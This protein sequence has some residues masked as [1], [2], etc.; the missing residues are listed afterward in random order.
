ML[1]PATVALLLAVSI[2]SRMD[3]CASLAKKIGSAYI[4][5]VATQYLPQGSVIDHRS[6]GLDVTYQMT[7]APPMPVGL[8]RAI[9]NV[10]T[11]LSS[12]IMVEAWLPDESKGRLLSVGNRKFDGC[13]EYPQMAHGMYLGFATVSSNGGHNGSSASALL[14]QPKVLTDHSWRGVQQATV[15]GKALVTEYYGSN[16]W[17]SYH[18]GCATGARQGIRVAQLDPEL[19]DGIVAGPPA[20]NFGTIVMWYG[21]VLE[22][23]FHGN[24]TYLTK[25]NWDLVHEEMLSQCNELDGAEDDIIKDPRRCHLETR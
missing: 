1:F 10:T 15:A 17:K 25:E 22:D 7:P 11:S 8:C 9:L 16:A 5:V 21:A 3:D 18:I 6:E 4:H 24:D 2:A 20:S 19:F 12:S 14:D 13:V 23:I